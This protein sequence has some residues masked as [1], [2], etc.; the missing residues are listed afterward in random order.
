VGLFL[1]VEKVKPYKR[2]PKTQLNQSYKTNL[3]IFVFNMFVM[4]LLSTTTVLMLIDI[5]ATWGI[6]NY[7]PI[8]ITKMLISFLLIDFFLY[9]WHRIS[10]Q[11]DFLWM[12]HKV[13]HNDPYMNV[14]TGFRIHI[15]ELFLLTTMKTIFILLVGIDQVA[16]FVNE[17][18]TTMFIAFHHSN[19]RYKEK[20]IRKVFITPALH[21]THHSTERN[22]HDTNY[23]AVFSIWDRILNSLSD[24]KPRQIGIKGYSPQSFWNLLKFGFMIPKTIS[25]TKPYYP[26]S[27]HEMTSI[28]AYYRAEKRE[29]V[30]GYE[31]GDWLISEKEIHAMVTAKVSC[32]P[33]YSFKWLVPYFNKKQL[34][35]A[36]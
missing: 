1:I 18:I 27:I 10:H 6:V 31:L 15:G 20:W 16:V 9:T 34:A 22:E 11:V 12:F 21:Y 2:L 33:M 30:S 32:E 14:T 8:P 23:G 19:I 25:S 13:H 29:F 5:P 7:I 28:A 36:A 24:V 3:G 4:S 35:L 26:V 17:V